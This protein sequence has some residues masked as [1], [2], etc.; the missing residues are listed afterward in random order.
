MK[1]T[2]FDKKGLKEIFVEV[3]RVISEFEQN[4]GMKEGTYGAI[5]SYSSMMLRLLHTYPIK[6]IEEKILNASSPRGSME[7]YWEPFKETAKK[8]VKT[9]SGSPDKIKKIFGFLK[10]M[11]KIK[12]E[13]VK[14][15][16]KHSKGNEHKR[17][18]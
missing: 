17:H 5:R 11:S 8:I 15:F 14:K 7:K 13:T 1:N 9:H 2:E 16:K 6:E 12:E 18:Y 4:V 10:W 3:N